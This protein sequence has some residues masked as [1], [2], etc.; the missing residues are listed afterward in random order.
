LKFP[1][2]TYVSAPVSN[3]YVAALHRELR[4]CCK[5]KQL[6]FSDVASREVIIGADSHSCTL[7]A[8]GAFSTGVGATDMAGILALRETWLRVPESRVYIILCGLEN[9]ECTTM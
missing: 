2:R 1:H 9:I 6:H 5:Q 7:G 4:E 8:F 3:S